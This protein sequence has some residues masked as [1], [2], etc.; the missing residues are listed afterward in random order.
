[1]ANIEA[2]ILIHGMGRT[3]R[4]MHKLEQSLKEAGF[5]TFNHSYPS[6]R[7]TVEES[8]NQYIS[9]AL[10]KLKPY[11][12]K[13]IHFVTH[14]LGG[15]LVRYYLS[16]HSI[17][18]L[19]KVVMLA[20]PNQGSHVTEKYGKSWWYKL[21]TKKAGQQLYIKDNS[22]LKNLKPLTCPTLVIAGN[23]SS[24]P[25]FNHAF[26][27]EHDG[28][29]AVESTQLDEMTEHVKMKLGH[30]FMMNDSK[31][32]RMCRNFI[33]TGSHSKTLKRVL[34]CEPVENGKFI[35]SHERVVDDPLI[36]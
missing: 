19:G 4:S 18:K 1:M 23:K 35:N 6:T 10:Q 26:D 21:T 7:Q 14:S 9:N 24:D 3:H 28:K 27:H 22:L 15:I 11:K 30:T 17:E 36:K 13:Q 20:P 31:L 8:A 34:L 16:Q 29:V 2:V 32:Q 5:I 12:P 33:Q 25:W